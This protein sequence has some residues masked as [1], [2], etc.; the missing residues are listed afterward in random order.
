VA[1]RTK[2]KANNAANIP[3]SRAHHRKPF[4]QS[5]CCKCITNHVDVYMERHPPAS[6]DQPLTSILEG[7]HQQ[8][9]VHIKRPHL[10]TSHS[11]LKE[12]VISAMCI[13]IYIPCLMCQYCDKIRQQDTSD[14]FIYEKSRKQEMQIHHPTLLKFDK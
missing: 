6:C 13:Y 9:Y 5:I 2:K 7:K 11:K 10:L 3:G 8:T 12:P 4:L 14:A 1:D